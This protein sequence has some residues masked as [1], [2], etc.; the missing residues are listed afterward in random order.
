MLG[1]LKTS[2]ITINVIFRGENIVGKLVLDAS[3]IWSHAIE[4]GDVEEVEHVRPAVVENA[5]LD[6]MV[7]SR[8]PRLPM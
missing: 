8:R 5:D 1:F 3:F 4:H 6:L 2:L 7:H